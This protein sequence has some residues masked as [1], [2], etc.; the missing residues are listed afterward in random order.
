MATKPTKQQVAQA[1]A[2]AGGNDPM[3]FK[4]SKKQAKDLVLNAAM[5]VGPGKFVKGVELAAK[6]ARVVGLKKEVE[7]AK[8]ARQ[9]RANAHQRQRT[10]QANA[11]SDVNPNTVTVVKKTAPAPRIKPEPK[12]THAAIPS[13]QLSIPSSH[14]P[15]PPKPK[16][17]DTGAAP[18]KAKRTR[19][20]VL[21]PGQNNGR[22][23]RKVTH[24]QAHKSAKSTVG[25]RPFNDGSSGMTV[26][27]DRATGVS[28]VLPKLTIKPGPVTTRTAGRA[29]TKEQLAKRAAGIAKTKRDKIFRG[30]RKG[31]SK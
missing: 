26:M 10:R 28:S 4:V 20:I 7:V 29:L 23:L 8:A 17:P 21:K 12:V 30:P 13:G 3:K 11:L 22:P 31:Q 1:K 5:F 19:E 16:V 24:V 18:S 2:R 15:R 6:A 9:L 14:A 27:S 25:K